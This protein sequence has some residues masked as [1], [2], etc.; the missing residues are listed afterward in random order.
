M[1]LPIM[2]G[3]MHVLELNGAV[4]VTAICVPV[5]VEIVTSGLTVMEPPEMPSCVSTL[6]AAVVAAAV[7]FPGVMTARAPS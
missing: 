3:L 7:V 2:N 5:V 1:T 4:T 6:D